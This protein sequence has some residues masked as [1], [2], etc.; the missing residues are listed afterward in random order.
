MAKIAIPDATLQFVYFWY[1]NAMNRLFAFF[2]VTLSIIGVASAEWLP[3]ATV[4]TAAEAFPAK[5]AIG[6]SVLNGR[7]LAFFS[8]RGAL[9]IARYEPSGYAVFSGSDLVGPV[10]AFSDKVFSE[11]DEGEAFFTVL[12][13]AS[14]GCW[15]AEE[16]G[17]T[18]DGLRRRAKWRK[19]LADAPVRSRAAAIDPEAHVTVAPFLKTHW[20]QYQPYNDFAPVFD[21]SS[22][23]V[24]RGRAPC[25]CVAT[26]AAQVFNYWRWPTRIDDVRSYTHSFD[27]G[28]GYTNGYTVRFDGN[29]PLDWNSIS[30]NYPNQGRGKWDMRGTVK[31]STRFSVARLVHLCD[32]LAHMSFAHDNSGSTFSFLTGDTPW[33]T[34]CEVHAFEEGGFTEEDI[35]GGIAAARAD[36]GVLRPILVA[37]PGHAVVGHGWSE[38][39][40]D[41]YIYLNYGWH[42]DHD[43]YYNL[44]DRASTTRV[45]HVYTGFMPRPEAQIDPIPAVLGESV[46]LQWHV[47]DCW[48]GSINECA[49]VA[50]TPDT[51]A[52]TK[53]SDDF[54]SEMGESQSARIRLD[55]DGT[56]GFL[57][58]GTGSYAWKD[59]VLLSARSVLSYDISSACALSHLVTI[60]ARF[61]GGPWTV[62]ST[63]EINFDGAPKTFRKVS[64][65]LGDHGGEI[66]Q[67]RIK[68]EMTG[69]SYYKMKEEPIVSIDNFL[70]SDVYGMEECQTLDVDAAST[71]W[72]FGELEPGNR[73]LFAVRLTTESGTFESDPV[74]AYSEG[75][76]SM[77]QPGTLSFDIQ[78]VEYPATTGNS[79]WSIEAKDKIL[80]ET[81]IKTDTWNGGFTCDLGCE[82]TAASELAF[83]WTSSGL[84]GYYE[85]EWCYDTIVVSFTSDDGSS[86][87]LLTIKNEE[88]VSEARHVSIPL[89]ALAGQKGTIAV[90]FN[91]AGYQ[92]SYDDGMTFHDPRITAISVPVLPKPT[93]E[94]VSKEAP[95]EMPRISSVTHS[96]STVQEGLFAECSMTGN[97]FTVTCSPSVVSLE[98]HVSA[99]SFVPDSAIKVHSRG[100]GKFVV[101]VDGGGIPDWAERTRAIL[102]LAATDA[103]GTTVYRDFSLR[104]STETEGDAYAATIVSVG[105][106]GVVE[107]TAGAYVVTANDGQT[108]SASDFSFGEMPKEA[109]DVSIAAGGKSAT[110]TLKTPVFGVAY[111]EAEAEKDPDDPS[112]FLVVV[113]ESLLDDIPDHAEYEAVSALPVKAFPGLCYQAGWGSSLDKLTYGQKVRAKKEKSTLYLGV[114]RQTGPSAFYKLTVSD[115]DE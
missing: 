7:S 32:S 60:E 56:L 110:V 90:S 21:C 29:T 23:Y 115:K 11:P 18:E 70:L 64:V 88:T 75:E 81:S 63:P 76:F 14:E 12:A 103:S 20:H 3:E 99:A 93:F 66:A 1:N 79:A 59:S 83:D 68:C 111:V 13:G 107:E 84:Y 113:D 87:N 82:L 71:S 8:A 105:G 28:Q 108:L 73:Y 101:E 39:G 62:V 43:G 41:K 51:S 49:I 77:P 5:D 53:F 89:A 57:V 112:G 106:K 109:Y 92:S 34:K 33:Y 44:D 6:S 94:T 4:R 96:K 31:E 45:Q 42:G 104:F 78:D 54:S 25:G 58:G 91:H 2:T 46:Q 86:T 35:E 80:S 22:N 74:M 52:L 61:D 16:T 72:N 10:I 37:I 36:I 38:D 40:D 9:W 100:N 48:A 65:F 102:T 30:N 114:I 95:A 26:A 15:K 67:F 24:Y 47:P 17:E 27:N 85:G 55:S 50:Y 97:V 19:L 69:D 98:A